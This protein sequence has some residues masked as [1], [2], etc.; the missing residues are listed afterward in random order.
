MARWD[1]VSMLESLVES[2]G[3]LSKT[4]KRSQTSMFS[5]ISMDSGGVEHQSQRF[6]YSGLFR[7]L[8]DSPSL[9]QFLLSKLW[10]FI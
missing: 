4:Q 9:Q 8:G 10:R 6:E 3:L 2:K 1:V 5:V 7:L